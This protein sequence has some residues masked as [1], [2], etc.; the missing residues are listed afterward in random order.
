M[1]E[2][3]E[4]GG[5]KI[6]VSKD[7]GY[8]A[9]AAPTQVTPLHLVIGHLVI[10]RLVIGRLVIGNRDKVKINKFSSMFRL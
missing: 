4:D 3:T 6:T 2:M 5:C 1:L 9:P 10:G 8:N 7:G